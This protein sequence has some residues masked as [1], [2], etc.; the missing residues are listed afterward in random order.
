M[1]Q[2]DQMTD[3]ELDREIELAQDSF[4]IAMESNTY[5]KA[6]KSLAIMY[7]LRSERTNRIVEKL[8]IKMA[9]MQATING[10]LS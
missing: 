8:T 6:L 3:Q 2:L 4:I 1:K 5:Q 10:R 9:E 7:T